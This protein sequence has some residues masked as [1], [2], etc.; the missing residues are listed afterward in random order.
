MCQ[1]LCVLSIGIFKKNNRDPTL[2]RFNLVTCG[3]LGGT[4][5]RK[6]SSF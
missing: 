6:I 5:Y 2:V 1:S 3:D 4:N